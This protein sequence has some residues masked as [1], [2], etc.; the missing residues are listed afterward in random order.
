LVL[1]VEVEEEWWV[2]A[3][4]MSELE[5]RRREKR[6]DLC[7]GD[8]TGAGGGEGSRRLKRGILLRSTNETGTWKIKQPNQ[9]G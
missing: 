4:W 1:E 8:A 7:V 6:P 3:R 9:E 2:D 5:E